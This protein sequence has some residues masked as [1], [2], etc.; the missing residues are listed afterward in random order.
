MTPKNLSNWETEWRKGQLRLSEKDWLKVFPQAKPV[1]KQLIKE[2]ENQVKTLS[3]EIYS[4]LLRTYKLSAAADEFSVWFTEK[5]IEIWRGSK[6][7]WLVKNIQR[8]KWGL[9]KERPGVITNEQIRR[10]KDFPF[11][12]L[13]ESKRNFALCPFHPDK[14]PSF[15]IKNNFGFCFACGWNGDTIKFLMEKNGLNFKEAVKHLS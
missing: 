15:Y 1:A 7:E 6:L 10:A 3:L 5:V 8:L 4:D 9:T 2:Y 14:H 13:I 12:K 11:E